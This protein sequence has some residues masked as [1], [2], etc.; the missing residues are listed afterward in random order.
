MSLERVLLVILATVVV[1]GLAAWALGFGHMWGWG[2]GGMHGYDRGGM[3]TGGLPRAMTGTQ[4]AGVAEGGAIVDPVV[5]ASLG[6]EAKMGQRAYQAKCASCHGEHAAGIKGTAP[7]LVHKIYEPSHH[8]DFAFVMAVKNGVKAHHWPFGD[9]PPVEGL[10]QA[11]AL[12]I[13]SYVREL[14]RVN[15]IGIN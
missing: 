6:A 13:A 8:A 1:L 11:D 9:M 4:M 12:A 5:P 15:G 10:T 2:R 14:Q 3:M 7:P